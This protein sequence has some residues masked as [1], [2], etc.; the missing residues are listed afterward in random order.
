MTHHLILEQYCFQQAYEGLKEYIIS[1]Y[2]DEVQH[3]K[4]ND[5]IT[6]E[7]QLTGDFFAAII[8]RV[9]YFCSTEEALEI[10]DFK[11]VIP[12]AINKEHS[13][14][15]IYS[16]ENFRQREINHGILIFKITRISE[17]V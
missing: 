6:I 5:T 3:Y 14:D 2:E 11:K 9:N 8:T 13:F 17:L 16:L 10:Y 15:M 7:D 12:D 4:D 1:I